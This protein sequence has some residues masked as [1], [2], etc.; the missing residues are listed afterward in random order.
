MSIQRHRLIPSASGLEQLVVALAQSFRRVRGK[1]AKV[2]RDDLDMRVPVEEPGKNESR[3]C[4][5]GVV[6]PADDAPAVE[7]A[8]VFGRIIGAVGRTYRVKQNWNIERR[9]PVEQRHEPRI[10]ERL[11]I[12]V[13]VDLHSTEAMLTNSAMKLAESGV[14]VV[15]RQTRGGA[16]EPLG[17]SRH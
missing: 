3:H 12:D 8:H 13:G 9:D 15:Q 5:D 1:A 4:G 6:Q 10:V 2:M 17:E 14:D 7:A 16:N 11:S